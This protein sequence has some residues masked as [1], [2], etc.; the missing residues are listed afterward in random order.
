MALIGGITNNVGQA[1][2]LQYGGDSTVGATPVSAVVAGYANAN[3]TATTAQGITSYTSNDDGVFEVHGYAY[4][5]NGTSGQTITFAVEYTDAQSG[6][7]ETSYLTTGATVLS[8][9]AATANGVYP[10]APLTIVAK[11]G[12][13]TTVK[14]TDAGGTPADY[15]TAVISQIA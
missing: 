12:T 10:C 13:T 5:N 8:A 15:V 1:Q 2:A 7:S 9:A 11:G 14:Y 6:S 4:I 3:V